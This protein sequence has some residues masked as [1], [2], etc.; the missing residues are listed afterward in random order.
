MSSDPTGSRAPGLRVR[1]LTVE[2]PATTGAA[3]R[4]QRRAIVTGLDLDLEPG[5]RLAITG[6]SS[7]DVTAVLACLAGLRAPS[8]GSITVDDAELGL[9]PEPHRLGYMG[10]DHRLIGTL[11]A[12]ENVL[13]SLIAG[14]EPSTRA[15][16]RRA[17]AQLEALGLSP[18]TWHN[19]VEQLSG[20]QQQRVALARALVLRPRLVVLDEPT[21]ELDPDS[22][23]LVLAVLRDVAADGVCCVLSSDDDL[24][25][26]SCS[27]RVALAARS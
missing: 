1:G 22:V 10:Q 9:S 21:S 13:V 24:L 18:A 15:T 19:L 25:L 17:E 26:D 12:V 11:T 4:H 3:H 5:Q 8:G 6:P 14:G 2:E 23:E 16:G 20:G 7:A 27:R